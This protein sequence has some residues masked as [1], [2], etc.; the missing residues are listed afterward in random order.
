MFKVVFKEDAKKIIVIPQ[1]IG[2]IPPSSEETVGFFNYLENQFEGYEV[3]TFPSNSEVI[4]L[5]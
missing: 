2:G 5:K 1:H 3:M 4:F